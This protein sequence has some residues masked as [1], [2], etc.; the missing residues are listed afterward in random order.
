M[1]ASERQTILLAAAGKFLVGGGLALFVLPP[2]LNLVIARGEGRVWDVA[3]REY[4]GLPPELGACAPR[5]CASGNNGGG[6]EAAAEGHDVLLRT[7]P[8]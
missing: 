1:N 5:P 6:R 7:S 4:L 3:G 8:R 2:E